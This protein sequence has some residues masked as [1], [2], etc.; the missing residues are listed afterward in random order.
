PC[1]RVSHVNRTA[2]AVLPAVDRQRH[3]DDRSGGDALLDL[4]VLQGRRLAGLLLREPRDAVRADRG[5][6]AHP[7]PG[8]GPGG[9]AARRLAL[10]GRGRA[11]GCRAH[12]LL[13]PRGDRADP[14]GGSAGGGAH[15][16]LAGPVLRRLRV[17][18]PGSV[19]A[20]AR[21]A[22]ALHLGSGPHPT[23]SRNG[24]VAAAARGRLD[25]T[26]S[27]TLTRDE[28]RSRASFLSTDSYDIRLDLTTD[29]RTFLTET[30]LRFSSTEARPTF[31]DLIAQSVEEIE[32]NGE[33]LTD[34]ASRFDGARV[35]LPELAEGANTLRILATG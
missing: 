12:R 1:W 32:L 10:Q 23:V 25:P 14:G 28:A 34:P 31:V 11:R 7:G 30:T 15:R 5:G 20:A 27:G 26:P 17:L 19:L 16:R 3:P 18:L 13:L 2:H 29:E 9:A 4:A 6:S 8:A 21:A 33:L 22:R 35:Q 24:T